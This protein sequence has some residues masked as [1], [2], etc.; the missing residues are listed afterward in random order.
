MSATQDKSQKTTFVYSNL[1]QLYKKGKE[2]AVNAPHV[3]TANEPSHIEAP[4]FAVPSSRNVLKSNDLKAQTEKLGV[5]V[6]EYNPASLMK[7]RVAT[8]PVLKAA[9]L[10]S[11]STSSN[12][13]LL[14]LKE[15]LKNLNDL[16][17]RLRFMLQELEELA[18]S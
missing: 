4:H 17:A 16:H 5:Q 2:A 12:P 11:A 1:Y 15:N 14:A 10:S 18:K 6:R 3:P 9:P 8:P 13:A 7:K